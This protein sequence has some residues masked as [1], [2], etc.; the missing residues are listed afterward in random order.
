MWV[1]VIGNIGDGAQ[2]ILG[3]F[4]SKEKADRYA[5][6]HQLGLIGYCVRELDLIKNVELEIWIKEPQ[7]AHLRSLRYKANQPNHIRS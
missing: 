7:H 5:K 3:L 1:I 2:A 6:Y 4:D